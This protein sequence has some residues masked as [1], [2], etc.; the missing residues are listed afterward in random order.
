MDRIEDCISFLAGKVAQQ[1]T[2]RARELLA[3]HDVTP[4]QYAVLKVLSDATSM[5][6]VEIGRRMV[7]DSAS[8]TGILDRMEGQGLV[9]RKANPTDRR[10][11]LIVTTHRAKKLLPVLDDEMDRLNAE[12]RQVMSGNETVF[13]QSLRDLSDDRKWKRNV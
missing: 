13:F 2:R 4:V 8:V 3:P 9:E 10:A 7:L 11:Q 5:S 12:A 6:G 1:I